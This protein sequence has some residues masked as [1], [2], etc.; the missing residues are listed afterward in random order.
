MNTHR[1]PI[2][3]TRERLAKA[4]PDQVEIVSA[5]ENE[6]WQA[7]R[8][9]D[10]PLAKLAIAASRDPAKGITGEQFQAGLRFYSDAYLAG[11]VP[12]KAMDFTRMRV[13]CEGYKDIPDRKIAA[14]TRYNHALKALDRDKYDILSWVVV[15]E[16]ELNDYAASEFP[17]F[18]QPRERRAIALKL[19]RSALSQLDEHYYPKRKSHGIVSA[20]AMD[21]RPVINREDVAS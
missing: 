18:P 21:A 20:M 13:D 16:T 1:E 8:I 12:G 7:L 15:R 19:L 3:P 6:H 5:G 2:G 17:E 9:H 14:Q 10:S 4:E 11:M